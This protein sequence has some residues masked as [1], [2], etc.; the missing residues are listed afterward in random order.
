[1]CLPNVLWLRKKNIATTACKL[2]G[3]CTSITSPVVGLNVLLE[4]H[5]NTLREVCSMCKRPQDMASQWNAALYAVACIISTPAGLRWGLSHVD[6]PSIVMRSLVTPNIYSVHAVAALLVSACATDR[7][8][9]IL[10]EGGLCEQLSRA[11]RC[12]ALEAMQGWAVDFL[13]AVATVSCS[14]LPGAHNGLPRP[15]EKG[16][17][18]DDIGLL[19]VSRILQ[20]FALGDSILL[21][22]A[23]GP[24]RELSRK[25]GDLLA[26]LVRLPATPRYDGRC[27]GLGHFFD[28]SCRE[29]H[30][31]L[32]IAV[33]ALFPT[34]EETDDARSYTA[35]CLLPSSLLSCTADLGVPARGIRQ[36]DKFTNVMPSTM[37][38]S[39]VANHAV[40]HCAQSRLSKDPGD[41]VSINER[42][43]PPCDIHGET[44]CCGN[45]QKRVS[46]SEDAITCSAEG[47]CGGGGED[48]DR[49]LCCIRE[50]LAERLE[51]FVDRLVSKGF[52]TNTTLLRT[53]LNACTQL[54]ALWGLSRGSG[55]KVG[56][57]GQTWQALLV[58]NSCQHHRSHPCLFSPGPC[59]RCN[60]NYPTPHPQIMLPLYRHSL[61]GCIVRIATS[62]LLAYGSFSSLEIC[63]YLKEVTSCASQ[64][65]LGENCAE[66]TPWK[67]LLRQLWRNTVNS[68]S[69]NDGA[70]PD[71]GHHSDPVSGGDDYIDAGSTFTGVSGKPE[72]S[73]AT[74]AR[75]LVSTS[76]HVLKI[77]YE[78]DDCSIR[79]NCSIEDYLSPVNEALSRPAAARVKSTVSH[80]VH[81]RMPVV[82]PKK[83]MEPDA[84]WAGTCD[85]SGCEGRHP[86]S[87]APPSKLSLE[88]SIQHQYPTPPHVCKHCEY[89]SCLVA[90]ITASCGPLLAVASHLVPHSYLHR[91]LK[92]SFA[93]P[94]E[95]GVV[96][97]S[98]LTGSASIFSSTLEN[99]A[100]LASR[101]TCCVCTSC[102]R[103]SDLQR[104]LDLLFGVWAVCT[105]LYRNELGLCKASS[106]SAEVSTGQGMTPAPLCV[107]RQSLSVSSWEAK[108]AALDVSLSA[109][110]VVLREADDT[111]LQTTS[112]PPLCS[113]RPETKVA[114][115]CVSVLQACAQLEA[116]Y[117]A[118]RSDLAPLRAQTEKLLAAIQEAAPRMLD[119]AAA[120]SEV[121]LQKAA[122]DGWR[123]VV[124]D[125]LAAVF[126]GSSQCLQQF[127]IFPLRHTHLFSHTD[128]SVRECAVNALEM[129]TKSFAGRSVL[130]S[131][132]RTKRSD[133]LLPLWCD[134]DEYVREMFARFVCS[135][136]LPPPRDSDHSRRS[137][138]CCFFGG[139]VAL[140]GHVR[141][142][143]TLPYSSS[144]RPVPG[145]LQGISKSTLRSLWR[146]VDHVI[147][148]RSA[149]KVRVGV[150]TRER[151]DPPVPLTRDESGSVGSMDLEEVVERS[152]ELVRKRPRLENGNT[153]NAVISVV[154]EVAVNGNEHPCSDLLGNQQRAAK[155]GSNQVVVDGDLDVVW[156]GVIGLWTG[157]RD[158]TDAFRTHQ[159]DSGGGE[160]LDDGS[161]T[162]ADSESVSGSDGDENF[163]APE[164]AFECV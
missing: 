61:P 104:V 157:L 20:T 116:D 162:S 149:P 83:K 44:A 52:P 51:E 90:N 114:P 158:R 134:E 9:E 43:L 132:L 60:S 81:G 1:M 65:R 146:Q 18:D 97:T 55:E 98:V 30:T 86:I 84:Y 38:A 125:N 41:C 142:F 40:E 94:C 46:N 85:E 47:Y 27:C 63:Q 154:D 101:G 29:A 32:L 69:S 14:N 78:S 151:C 126:S 128:P 11:V 139:F 163:A 122:L 57:T 24:S 15:R 28:T 64:A 71:I 62:V 147:S 76:V 26:S 50:N 36:P 160:S 88:P 127:Q 25:I 141:L 109:F 21:L 121:F 119:A 16:N 115:A 89:C 48:L 67:R 118:G 130:D 120:N 100:R 54:M 79:N 77:M 95:N 3:D 37:H 58:H 4:R 140:E 133:F 39:R 150:E 13:A 161:T 145:F 129:Y 137:E 92:G 59:Y 12:D 68:R 49:C 75:G 91:C 110:G 143:S 124:Q 70:K 80:D 106:E 34:S 19:A 108:D 155:C 159:R 5:E 73:P 107:G 123:K 111:T 105:R 7:E 35:L 135:L 31:R 74:Q 164:S 10:K 156:D 22:A 131:F 93:E 113:V 53:T 96:S 45:D 138:Y 99:I 42:V 152:V 2:I 8:T 6:V 17:L 112:P 56:A 144:S 87:A 148:L 82:T 72:F 33:K 103:V 153:E 136:P 117:V 102:E 23:C 66:G